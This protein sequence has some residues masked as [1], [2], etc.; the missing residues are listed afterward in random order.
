MVR[1]I[2]DLPGPPGLPL[3]GSALQVDPARFHGLV[4]EWTGRYGPIFCARLGSRRLLFLASPDTIAAVLRDRPERFGR[5]RA[6]E[7]LARQMGAPSVFS[8]NGDSWRRQRKLVMNALDV[9]HVEAFFPSLQRVAERLV[10]RWAQA[11]DTGEPLDV[12]GDLMRFTVDVT[13]G[14]AFGRD[15]NT[16]DSE[17]EP[18][19]HDIELIFDT[20]NRRLRAPFPWW[21]WIRRPRDRAFEQA[22]ARLRALTDRLTE[23]ARGRLAADPRPRNLI[24]ALLVAE[25]NEAESF[26]GQEVYGNLLAILLAGE[27]TTA[28]TLAWMLHYMTLDPALQVQA[29]READA[30]IGQATVPARYADLDRLPWID[31][32]ASEAL[33]LRPVGPLI[34]AQPTRDCM[35]E[36]IEVPR[37]TTIVL[38]MRP[39]SLDAT[40]FSEPLAFR[41]QR[42]LEP[43][44]VHE[45][46]V[47]MPFGSGSRSCPGRRLATAEI[48]TAMASVCHAFEF[49][50]ACADEIGE[51]YAITM[52]PVGLRLRVRRRSPTS[53]PERHAAAGA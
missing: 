2:E 31:A 17:T 29:R 14:L 7:S 32:V 28:N 24:E 52:Q 27:D 48:R 19:R 5:T 16:L 6:L 51:R 46:R 8:S 22:T 45:P 4:E 21:R 30:V 11:A 20:M 47:T 10:R 43:P 12:H 39:A 25:T 9:R 15:L 49:E 23:E 38:V 36:D 53:R 26:S 13:T 50:R 18:L 3:L 42:W 35:I 44:A 33:R 40:H 37:D 41:P 34:F 1:R